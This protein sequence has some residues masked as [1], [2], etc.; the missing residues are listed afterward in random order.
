MSVAPRKRYSLRLKPGT[1]DLGERTLVMG[2][3]NVTPDSFS[4]AGRHF[5]FHSALRE[6]LDLIVAGADLLDI[7][8][9][10]TRPQSE[11]V[12]VDVELERVIPIIEAI[13]KSSDIPISIDTTKADVAEAAIAAGADIIN[14]VSALR[15]DVRMADLAARVG[16][17]VILMHMQGTPK[18]MQ[19][20]PSYGSLFSEIIA[21]LEERIHYA[22]S[23]GIDREQ[24]VVDPGIGFGKT[25]AHN[26]AIV[27]DLDLFRSMDRPIL[28]GASRKRFIGSVL[29]RPVEDREVGTAVVNAVSIAAG[30]HIIRVHDVETHRQV[31]LMADALRDPEMGEAF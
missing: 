5:D 2:I 23:C 30:A 6:A 21:F 12:P 13:R 20:N 17:P 16:V 29:D 15:F 7:G 19:Q 4:D 22:A 14:D 31:A 26:L 8:G 27:R 1:I 25:V 24:I 18:T 28:M 10:S 3:L 9:E 11:P